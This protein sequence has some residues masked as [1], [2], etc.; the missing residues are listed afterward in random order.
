MLPIY[1]LLTVATNICCFRGYAVCFIY[2]YILN[3][4]ISYLYIVKVP[5]LNCKLM[6]VT[7]II[8][9]TLAMLTNDFNGK[10]IRLYV[11]YDTDRNVTYLLTDQNVAIF[12]N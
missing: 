10:I 6:W 4:C 7:L 11:S 5:M 12:T 9:L 8:I 2:I 1:H 3:V